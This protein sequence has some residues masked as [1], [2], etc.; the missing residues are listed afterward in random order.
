MKIGPLSGLV[1]GL[2]T[3]NA[4]TN[5]N[6]QS[7]VDTEKPKASAYGSDAARIKVS[8]SDKAPEATA[9]RASKVADLKAKVASGEY[10]PNSRDVA[11]ALIRDLFA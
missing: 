8:N 2:Q 1:S 11:A 9:D 10:K 5:S 7:A 6:R 3:S 4:G